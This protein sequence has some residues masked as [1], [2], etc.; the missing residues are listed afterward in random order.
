MALGSW[1]ATRRNPTAE[2]LSTRWWGYGQRSIVGVKP[3][4]PSDIAG[5]CNTSH[6]LFLISKPVFEHWTGGEA[7]PTNRTE[8]QR[9]WLIQGNNIWYYYWRALEWRCLPAGRLVIICHHIFLG[10]VFR[11][12]LRRVQRSQVVYGVEYTF[13]ELACTWMDALSGESHSTESFSNCQALLQRN[14]S[15]LVVL[16]RSST[17]DINI[18]LKKTSFGSS[19]SI[20]IFENEMGH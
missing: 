4:A 19:G 3:A 20:H 6:F 18:N 8:R 14:S 10:G 9:D 12:C 5:L 7:T 15:C 2:Q 1:T 13:I 17:C 16:H 11:L